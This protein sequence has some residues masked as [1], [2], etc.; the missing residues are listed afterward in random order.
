MSTQQMPPVE[1]GE[2]RSLSNVGDIFSDISR[3][4]STLIQQELALARAEATESAK[5][6]GKGAGMFSGAA[7]AIHFAALFISIALWWAVGNEIGRGWSALIGGVVWA[8]IGAVLAVKGKKE[9]KQVQGMP[10]T[11]Q[12]ARKVPD[13]LKGNEGVA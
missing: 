5:K 10:K 4:L 12:T 1:G 7:V 13:A 11:A 2:T 8:A 3:N 9:R 6:A